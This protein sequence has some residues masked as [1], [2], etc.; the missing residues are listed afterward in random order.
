MS[1]RNSLAAITMAAAFSFAGCSST[2]Q[3]DVNA[4]VQGAQ[5]ACGFLPLI[6]SVTAMLNANGT[7]TS[8]E[9]AVALICN[10]FKTQTSP[11]AST[12]LKALAPGA[13]VTIDVPVGNGK[14]VPV[15][16]T[17]VGG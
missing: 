12:H 1:F 14:V 16:G 6:S 17:V 9:S 13:Q 4:I 10:S 3:I 15:T 8:V 11:T 7:I 2:G 5:A